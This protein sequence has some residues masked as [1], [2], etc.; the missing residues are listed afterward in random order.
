[1]AKPVDPV[2][3]LFIPEQCNG[4]WWNDAVVPS[5]RG[6]RM[7]DERCPSIRFHSAGRKPLRTRG[8]EVCFFYVQLG[9]ARLFFSDVTSGLVNL[10]KLFVNQLGS[11]RSFFSDVTSG[12]LYLQKVFN[13]PAR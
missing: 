1:M 4:V 2:D 11:A 6:V 7:Q 12:L 3:L 9:S 10:Q 5:A 13:Q 8:G